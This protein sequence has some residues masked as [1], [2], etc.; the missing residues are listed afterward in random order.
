MNG[1]DTATRYDPPND[2]TIHTFS[3]EYFMRDRVLFQCILVLPVGA[4][5]DLLWELRWS[6]LE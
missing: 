2:I 4:L 5:T 1:A 6:Q 3:V